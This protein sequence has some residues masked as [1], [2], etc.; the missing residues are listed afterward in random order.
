MPGRCYGGRPYHGNGAI[1]VKIEGLPRA[2]DEAIAAELAARFKLR[3]IDLL[4][5]DPADCKRIYLPG[6]AEK[7]FYRDDC[8]LTVTVRH[9]GGKSID[10]VFEEE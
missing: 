7:Y 1:V 2:I 3:G 10:L 4:T 5:T 9:K 6:G 8:I